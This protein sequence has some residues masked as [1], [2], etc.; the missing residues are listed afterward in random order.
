MKKKLT[1]ATLV[2]G[3]SVVGGSAYAAS[4]NDM[5]ENTKSSE[6]VNLEEMAKEKGITL[7]ELTAQLEK[8]G[9]LTKAAE[10]TV[11]TEIAADS[12]SSETVNLEEMAKEKGVTLDELIAQLEKEGKL[13]KAAETT[14][15]KQV[16]TSNK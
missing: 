1:I 4:N 16:E 2:L 7:D 11:A 8:E 14:E 3:L 13:T 10:T 12:K 5:W 6:T 9:K 15:A